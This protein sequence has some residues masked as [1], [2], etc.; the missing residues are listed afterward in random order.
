M[1]PEDAQNRLQGENHALREQ[2]A[3]QDSQLAQRDERI[4]QVLQR[5]QSLEERLGKESHTVTTQVVLKSCEAA[6]RAG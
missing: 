3:L 2:V 6:S 1:K 5:M 4:G